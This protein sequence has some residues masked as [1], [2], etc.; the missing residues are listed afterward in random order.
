[1]I[2]S[3]TVLMLTLAVGLPAAAQNPF[4]GLAA[5]PTTGSSSRTPW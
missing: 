3:A 5:G 1:M 4:R 2:R